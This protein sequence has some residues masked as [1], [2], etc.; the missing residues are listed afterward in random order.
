MSV[1]GAILSKIFPRAGGAAQAQPTSKTAPAPAAAASAPPSPTAPAAAPP[2]VDVE[3]VLDAMARDNPQ[4]LNW[5]TSIVD[6]LKLL[7]IDSSF[8]NRKALADEL[9]YTGG[10]DSAAMNIWLHKAVMRK[11]AENGG[12]VP[13]SLR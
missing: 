2:P 11:L 12:L 8:A 5:R 1:F 9:G 6:L 13:D 4:Q 7:A 10:D 3:A